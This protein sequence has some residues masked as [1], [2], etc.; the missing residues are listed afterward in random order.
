MYN[1]IVYG[2]LL[3]KKELQKHNIDINKITY[4]KVKGFKRIFN[5]EPSWRIVDSINRAVMNIKEDKN[6]WFNA[7]LLKDLKE[8]YFKDLD[9]REKGYDR[10]K[11]KNG[12]VINYN[13]EVINNCIIYKGKKNKQNNEI[14]PNIDYFEICLSGAKTHFNDFY[15]DYINTT[16]LH[17]NKKLLSVKEFIKN[18]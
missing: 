6:S 14:L 5:Q 15:N 9:L 16:Y 7:I 12:D 3:N 18:V 10:K 8:Q 13:G 11:I 1:L 2:S 17:K 4:V